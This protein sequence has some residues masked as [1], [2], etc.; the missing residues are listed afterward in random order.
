MVDLA[1]L[2]KDWIVTSGQFT[3]RAYNNVYPAVDPTAAK[4]SLE[5]KVMVLTGASRGLG[6]LGIAPAFVK[7]GVKAIVLIATKATKLAA[8][9]EDL[10]KLNPA[11]ETLALSVDVTSNEQVAKAWAV[12]NARYPQVHVLVNNAGVETT[13]SDKTHEQDPDVYFRNFVSHH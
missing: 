2:P 13:D 10:R 5:G 3:N 6:A 4:N 1:A 7:A 11:L 12:I 8:V 9:E